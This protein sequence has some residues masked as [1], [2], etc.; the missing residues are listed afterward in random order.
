M[1]NNERFLQNQLKLIMQEIRK[2]G[3]CNKIKYNY[4][5]EVPG[6]NSNVRD[7]LVFNVIFLPTQ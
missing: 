5:C 6:T 3:R 4:G 1:Y 2:M 7:L